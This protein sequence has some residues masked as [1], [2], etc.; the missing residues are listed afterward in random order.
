MALMDIF[1]RPAP[2]ASEPEA[3]TAE[4]P[5]VP[6]SASN[7]LDIFGLGNFGVSA[8]GVTVNIENAL[9]VPAVWAAVNFLSGTL[10][11]L[12]ISVYRRTGDGR[13]RVRGALAS[14]IGE[15]VNDATT[16]F[17][18][19]KGAFDA[20]FTGGRSFTFIERN[21][22]GRVINLWPLDPGLTTV[23]R[24]LVNGVPAKRYYY[25]DGSVGRV[26]EAG[27]VIDLAFMLKSDGLR[28]RGPI[29]SNHDVIGMA[30]AA[31]QYASRFFQNGGVPPFAVTG[32]FVTGA[33]M[34]RAAD[35]LEA[36]VKR[37]AKDKR[38]ALVLPNGLEIKPIGADP[39][40]SQLIEAQRFAIEQ[41]A[42]IYSLPPVFLQD[43]SRATYSNAE[44]QDLAFVKH[45]LLRWVR[46][47][48]Q[49]L[50]LKIFGRTSN[51]QFIEMNVDGLLRGDF[52]TR[53]DGY[54]AGIQHGVL[55][56]N[57]ARRRENL[58]D[59]PDGESLFMQGAMVPISQAGTPQGAA[60]DVGNVNGN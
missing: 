4:N 9:G 28:H 2:M 31:T 35:D 44:Q 42:R 60:P 41:I 37:A 46:Q 27:E 1:K 52:K 56:P 23:R 33:A 13:E 51:A 18:W 55:T 22:A 53:M 26:Y 16:S 45:T 11:A 14:L 10:A 12:P 24:E 15:V 47:F 34:A 29:A 58:P 43:L 5:S 50:N 21:A 38:Q 36:A 7:F 59:M 30:I 8:A 17:E 48:E 32:Q 25:A 20:V 49:E 6:I 40:K 54:S 39:E 57:E 19:R 3:R